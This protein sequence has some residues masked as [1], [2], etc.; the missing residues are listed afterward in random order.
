MKEKYGFVYI[1]F[2]I[3]HKRFYIGCHWGSE[4]DG[5]ICSSRW[6]RQSYK[7]RSVDFKRR[8]ISRVYSNR[9][10]LLV[11]EGKW[12]QLISENQL[13]NRY[14]NLTN[15]TNGHWTSDSSKRLTVGQK[16]SIANKGRISSAKGIPLSEE[17][18]QKLST[19]WKGKSKNYTR[20]EETRTKISANSRRLQA[21]G[22]VGMAG[23]RHSEAT[24]QK[25]SQ[26]NAMNDPI[27]RQKVIDAKRGI[28]WLINGSTK[29]MATPGTEKFNEL[30]DLGYKVRGE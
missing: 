25:M 9:N 26:N 22:R 21:E 8:I 24:K 5:Y 27:N 3:K 20:S 12:L 14:Y 15:H 4:D 11:E 6:M 30:I 10:D 7:R 18:K 23:K 1:W 19:M 28:R 17:R 13:G 2:D 16:I 29:K